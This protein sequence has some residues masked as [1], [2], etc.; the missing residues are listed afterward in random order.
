[1]TEQEIKRILG[2]L[3]KN[4]KTFVKIIESLNRYEI[5]QLVQKIDENYTDGFGLRD[6][7]VENFIGQHM[8]NNVGDNERKT[9]MSNINK[10]VSQKNK[11]DERRYY[12][13]KKRHLI[14]LRDNHFIQIPNNDNNYKEKHWFLPEMNIFFDFKIT[15]NQDIKDLVNLNLNEPL[16]TCSLFYDILQIKKGETNIRDQYTLKIRNHAI[17]FNFSRL[18]IFQEMQNI[19]RREYQVP[20]KYRGALTIKILQEEFSMEPQQITEQEIAELQIAE[21]RAIQEQIAKPKYDGWQNEYILNEITEQKIAELQAE[22]MQIVRRQN[23]RLPAEEVQFAQQKFAKLEIEK[24]QIIEQKIAKMQAIESAITEEQLTNIL[25]KL[26]GKNIAQQAAENLSKREVNKFIGSLQI[27]GSGIFDS[28]SEKQ[29]VETRIKNIYTYKVVTMLDREISNIL[30]PDI[31]RELMSYQ[32]ELEARRLKDRYKKNYKEKLEAHRLKKRE[33][34]LISKLDFVS[35]NFIILRPSNFK[36]GFA[37]FSDLRLYYFGCCST[38]TFFKDIVIEKNKPG[39]L[40]YFEKFLNEEGKPCIRLIPCQLL[41]LKKVSSFEDLEKLFLVEQK[42]HPELY[43]TWKTLLSNNKLFDQSKNGQFAKNEIIINCSKFVYKK[44]NF[45]L[46]DKIMLKDATNMIVYK[47]HNFVSDD[48]ELTKLMVDKFRAMYTARNVMNDIYRYGGAINT[49][50]P[51]S[52]FIV[53]NI[54]LVDINSG[55]CYT[56]SPDVDQMAKDYKKSTNLF[57]RSWRED[58]F[59]EKQNVR[60]ALCKEYGLDEEDENNDIVIKFN[61]SD[62]EMTYNEGFAL[63][64]GKLTYFERLQNDKLPYIFIEC[65][66][67]KIVMTERQLEDFIKDCDGCLRLKNYHYYSTKENPKFT[68]YEDILCDTN[69]S[70]DL[71]SRPLTKTQLKKINSGIKFEKNKKQKTIT[72]PANNSIWDDVFADDST[73]KYTLEDDKGENAGNA[74]VNNINIPGSFGIMTSRGNSLQQASTEQIE[75]QTFNTPTANDANDA[76]LPNNNNSSEK[77]KLKALQASTKEF[78]EREKNEGENDFEIS[79]D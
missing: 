70:E 17:N 24:Q 39:Y 27:D 58:L 65:K 57:E 21:L 78:N 73:R 64:N 2:L 53:K 40:M 54:D 28:I 12:M 36:E 44:H 48:K 7:N 56:R 10:I 19:L 67:K 47:K 3:T 50:R 38:R 33:I 16:Y 30:T 49:L 68:N 72:A 66:P 69:Y 52:R 60:N 22:E 45:G 34:Q 74:Y 51:K 43:P 18:E 32:E 37:L 20:L 59:K 9:I 79:L 4:T 8:G 46:D 5:L 35:K 25:I 23:S 11:L 62:G 71:L 63:V 41:K 76:N 61:N 26:E 75:S 6:D 14:Q 15:K 1:M 77:T 55:D 29:Y 42:N 31:Q 13:T